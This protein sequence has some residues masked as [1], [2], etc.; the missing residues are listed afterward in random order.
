M[1]SPA[2]TLEVT[3]IDGTTKEL[4]EL[5]RLSLRQL[6]QFVE[7]LSAKETIDA[8]V[9]ATGK[10]VEWVE[11]MSDESYGLLA[12]A[13]HSANFPRAMALI[14]KDPAMAIGLAPYI[15][16]MLK[17]DGM[18]GGARSQPLPSAESAEANVSVSS[19][20]RTTG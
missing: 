18:V 13:V 1:I 20:S 14:K 11:T 19:T 10:T 12:E 9:L 16:R 17:A 5:K 4:V 6:Y 3:L 2:T 8:I 15:G 7:V